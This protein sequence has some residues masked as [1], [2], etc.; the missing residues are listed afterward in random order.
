[1]HYHEYR[2]LTMHVKSVIEDNDEA[3][4]RLNMTF[5]AF[6]NEARRLSNLRF[7]EK[8]LRN[9]ITAWLQTSNVNADV[10]EMMNYII[11]MKDINPNFFYTVNLDE[12]CKF[13]SAILV[14]AR[15][16]TSYEY[17]GDVVS[18]DSTY[19]TN[20]HGLLFTSF[21]NVNHHGKS[22]FLSFALLGNEKIPSYEW[23]FSQWNSQ[24]V[25]SFEDNWF[26]FIAEYNIHNNT[27]LSDLYD[28]RRM[29]VPIYFKSE[30]WAVMRSLQR[31]ESMHAFYSGFLHSRTSLVQFVHEYDNVLGI[32]E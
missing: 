8:D 2:E 27:W 23:V 3:V 19:N 7:S 28:N 5:L 6:A 11:R 25:E 29:W 20:R 13:K 17:Y 9:Y 24:M 16:R 15:C 14:D 30:F 12:E 21:V 18:L 1:M 4:I 26:E 32:K 31:S 22:T 10:R